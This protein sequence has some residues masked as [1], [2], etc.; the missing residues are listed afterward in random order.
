MDTAVVT[1]VDQPNIYE[2]GSKQMVSLTPIEDKVDQSPAGTEPG[3]EPE[4]SSK[5]VKTFWDAAQAARRQN[6]RKSQSELTFGKFKV[7]AGTTSLT[8]ALLRGVTQASTRAEQL[9]KII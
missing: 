3:S 4:G 7:A 6:R 9:F 8:R 2:L 5:D 1:P